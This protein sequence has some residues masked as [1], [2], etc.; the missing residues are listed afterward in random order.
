MNTLANSF[1]EYSKKLSDLTYIIKLVVKSLILGL[2][3]AISVYAI[4]Q[5]V[6]RWKEITG[7]SVTIASVFIILDVFAGDVSNYAK[8][9]MMF[10][11]GVNTMGGIKT[12]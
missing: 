1:E 3:V 4:P 11:V 9:G 7:I 8:S 5:R 12:I 6:L 2:A 10:G